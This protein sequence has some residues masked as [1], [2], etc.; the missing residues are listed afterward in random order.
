MVLASN[1]TVA[2]NCVLK[3]TLSGESLWQYKGVVVVDL[4][5]SNQS[6]GGL[7]GLVVK[8]IVT[9]VQTA[10]ADYVP[11]AKRANYIALSTIPVGKYHGMYGKDMAVPFIDQ[12]PADKK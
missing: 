10:I 2:V 6:G 5:G 7:A 3:S 8:V 11:H 1:L 12:T 4:S 9:A